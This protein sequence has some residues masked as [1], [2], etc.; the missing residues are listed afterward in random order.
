MQLLYINSLPW[1]RRE[2]LLRCRQ[3]TALEVIKVRN[4]V[5]LSIKAN[6]SRLLL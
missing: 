4:R 2:P 6:A 5:F 3:S 1:P